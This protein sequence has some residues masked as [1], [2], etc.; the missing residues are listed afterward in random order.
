MVLPRTG[1]HVCNRKD[2]KGE[3]GQIP[4]ENGIADPLHTLTEIIGTRDILKHK[5]VRNLVAATSVRAKRAEN[6]V[7][8]PVDH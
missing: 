7:R 2:R 5:T 1:S 6:R 3:G 4:A 8:L